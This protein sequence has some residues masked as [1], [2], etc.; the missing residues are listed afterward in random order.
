MKL[1]HNRK[2]NM[3]T[4]TI[5]PIINNLPIKIDSLDSY[6]NTINQIPILSTEEERFL[7]E[8]LRLN[9]NLEAAQKLIVAHL[10]FV[11]H[12]ARGYIGYGL[13][14]GDLVQEGNIGLM[15]A[16]RRFNPSHGVRLVSFAVHWIRAEIHEFIIRNW[17]IVKI[18]TT[19][20]QRKLFF[21]LRSAKKRLG[22]LNCD[23]IT[24]VAKEL[25]VSTDTI[26]EMESRL[27]SQDLPFDYSPDMTKEDEDNR[28]NSP[29]AY[30]KDEHADPAN[31]LEKS[32]W[33]EQITKTLYTEIEKLDYRS[34]AIIKRRWLDD[35]KP[36]L[37]DLATEYQVSPERIR[38]IENSALNKLRAA[39]TIII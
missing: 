23:E 12:I 16:V 37:Q 11:V 30:L 32:T 35:N 25:G 22:W 38:Q 39:C 5:N 7:G 2:F 29:S 14:L 26:L 36:T 19:K 18:A 3:N 4:T 34:R 28:D 20:A 6:I 33:E 21:K 9:N 15:K 31:L 17:R 10:R 13:S 1:Q 24:T 8:S 27:N